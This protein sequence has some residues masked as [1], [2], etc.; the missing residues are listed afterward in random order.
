M[1]KQRKRALSPSEE[2]GGSRYKRPG[3]QT[4][5]QEE[6]SMYY[7]QRNSTFASG[8]TIADPSSASV[9]P[10]TLC[11]IKALAGNVKLL[12]ENPSA[13]SLL[14]FLPQSL[15]NLLFAKIAGRYPASL[16]P[17]IIVEV[18]VDLSPGSLTELVLDE[19]ESARHSTVWKALAR[20]QKVVD[21]NGGIAGGLTALS[22]NHLQI[23]EKQIVP[24]VARMPLL[25][26]F[27]ARGN[28]KLGNAVLKELA[29]SCPNLVRINVNH[30]AVTQEGIQAVLKIPSLKIAKFGFLKLGGDKTWIDFAENCKAQGIR[31][32]TL[33]NL[34]LR[35]AEKIS[36]YGLEVLLETT[37]S[38]AETLDL[39]RT[40]ASALDTL[41]KPCILSLRKLNISYCT[42]QSIDVLIRALKALQATGKFE[43]LKAGGIQF[44]RSRL[45]NTDVQAIA[46]FFTTLRHLAFYDYSRINDLRPILLYAA[47]LEYLD[48]TKTGITA[49][50]LEV[51]TASE[52]LKF[53]NLTG[54]GANDSFAPALARCSALE[55]LF[56]DKTFI[57][58]GYGS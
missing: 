7:E 39:L 21:V 45:Q 22:I 56:L 9:K 46:P 17:E 38:D 4:M 36:D 19:V 47:N 16:T 5:Q 26:R 28:M 48:L 55:T 57:E 31:V 27:E 11:A 58:G 52:K 49:E 29:K 51:A 35:E 32:A 44:R 10:L 30:T 50:D 54:T 23:P 40:P 8:S 6:L 3:K 37:C 53:L 43:V 14:N 18:F 12:M 20:S 1:P 25:T 2:D 15:L 24:A 34:K 41:L 13:M 42:V 33:K